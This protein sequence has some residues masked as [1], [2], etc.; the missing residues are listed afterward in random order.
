[1]APLFPLGTMSVFYV[2]SHKLDGPRIDSD[3]TARANI[4]QFLIDRYKAYTH[5]PAPVKGYWSDAQGNLV[6][7]V[8]ERF[9]VSFNGEDEFAGLIEFLVTLAADLEEESIYLT[10]GDRSYLVRRP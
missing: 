2:P 1:M 6:H 4:H 8:M 9:E 3:A 10:R 5:T 7:D